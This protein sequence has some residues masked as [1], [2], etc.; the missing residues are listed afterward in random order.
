MLWARSYR[1][2]DSVVHTSQDHDVRRS[3][4]IASAGGVLAVTRS[5][6]TVDR[7]GVGVGLRFHS[8]PLDFPAAAAL[9]VPVELPTRGGFVWMHRPHAAGTPIEAAWTF[10][11]MPWWPLMVLAAIPLLARAMRSKAPRPAL[12]RNP[13]V[14]CESAEPAPFTA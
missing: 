13:T 11:A 12:H 14:E 5:A 6:A 2:S 8:D 7:D 9:A 4:T 1:A 3:L 10:A